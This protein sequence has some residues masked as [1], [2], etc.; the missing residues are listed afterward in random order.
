MQ[1]F[2]CSVS[3]KLINLQRIIAYVCSENFIW[4]N[5]GAVHATA[6]NGIH[7][8]FFAFNKSF[9]HRLTCQEVERTANWDIP[10]VTSKQAWIF[11]QSIYLWCRT[12]IP[13]LFLFSVSMKSNLHHSTGRIF[14]SNLCSVCSLLF[15][16]TSNLLQWLYEHGMLRSV[17]LCFMTSLILVSANLR[18]A[19]VFFHHPVTAFARQVILT[20]V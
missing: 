1:I 5:L 18:S 14:S 17:C 4:T 13:F 11:K 10:L 19:H 8:D 12:T 2:R 16:E 15:F 20:K 6:D 7:A 9:I 3:L